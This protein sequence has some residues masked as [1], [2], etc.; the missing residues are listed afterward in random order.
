MRERIKHLYI[1]FA[2]L[3]V[4]GLVLALIGPFGTYEQLAAPSRLGYW[5]LV[6]TLNGVLVDLV[7][8]QV[9]A[10]LPEQTPMRRILAPFLGALFAAV[11]ATAIV[12]VANGLFGMGW[13]ERLLLLYS[14]VLFLLTVISTLVYTLQDLHEM[15]QARQPQQADD[16]TEPAKLETDSWA[17]FKERLPEP[18]EG[19]LLCLEM[20]DHY[21][22]VHTTAGKQL[23]LCRMDDAARELEDLGQRVHRSWWV[24][25]SAVAGTEKQGQ[26]LYLQLNDGRQVPVG[27]TYKDGLK[28]AGWF[29]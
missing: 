28:Q 1:S 9:D 2:G 21:L 29:R 16:T 10:Q 11:P 3:L 14:Q 26:R 13:P 15:A 24:A 5:L 25:E 19:E 6:A 8:R 20:H 23:I 17:R 22:A 12:A 4:I 7:I 18:M 27:R